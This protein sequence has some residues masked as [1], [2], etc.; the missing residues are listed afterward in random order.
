MSAPIVCLTMRGRSFKEGRTE[1]T[2][3]AYEWLP[4]SYGEAIARAGGIPVFLSNLTNPGQVREIM[5]RVDGLFL[6]GGEDVSTE[7]YG[8]KDEVGN[9][10]LYAE[11]D[12]VELASIAA[13]DDLGMPILGVC[14]GVQVLN[15]ARGGTLYQD[16]AQQLDSKPRDHS[17]GGTGMFVQTHEVE[18]AQ[19]CRLER[20]LGTRRFHG[21]TSH[22]QAVKT[23]GRDLVAVAHS[24]EDGV[25][26]A[27]EQ[28]GERFVVGVQWHPEVRAEDETTIRLFKSFVEA[29]AKFHSARS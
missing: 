8:E 28:P 2:P 27:V 26:E 11:R 10:S 25:I 24:P 12:Q 17:R 9:L 4:N 5:T 15:V 16:L 23:P 19:G 14:R 18:V 6:T 3:Y 7:Y 13:A 29:A 21:A 20:L 22:H 1:P